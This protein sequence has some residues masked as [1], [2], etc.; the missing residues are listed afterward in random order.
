MEFILVLLGHQVA[1]NQRHGGHVLDAVVAVSGVGQLADLGDDADRRLMGGDDD[2]IDFMQA[3]THL[4]MQGHRRFTG[5]L[6]VELGGEADL[7]Q[8]VLHHVA[9]K[10]LGETE[11]ALVFGFERQVLVGM[12]EQHIVEAPLRRSEHP[13]HTHLASQGHIGQAH[14]STGGIPRRPGFTRAGI[15]CMAIGTQ[16]LA[17]YECMGECR[18]ELLAIGPHEFGAHRRGRHLDQQHVVEADAIEGVF[19]G[20]HTL[21]LVGHD[22]GVEHHAHAQGR[23]ALRHAFL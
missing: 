1:K 12:A 14:A 20:Y 23:L 19:Q 10:R 5:S 15:G 17:V 21:N 7:E 13:G 4:G 2:A 11:R 3:V 9:G 8:H 16:G 22:H 6:G 18:Q